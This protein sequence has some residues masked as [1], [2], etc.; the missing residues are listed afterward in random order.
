[1]RKYNS[2]DFVGKWFSNVTGRPEFYFFIL[3]AEPQTEH[4]ALQE[5][6]TAKY[7]IL[8]P[9]GITIGWS[10]LYPRLMGQSLK[11][12]DLPKDAHFKVIH[13]IFKRQ[14]D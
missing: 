7:V 9:R 1:M 11:L 13:R 4:E 3:A 5:M 14:A 12:Y 2:E 6:I 10:G 8:G